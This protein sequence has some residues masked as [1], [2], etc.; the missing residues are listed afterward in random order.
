MLAASVLARSTV[1]CGVKLAWVVYLVLVISLSADVWVEDWA[2]MRGSAELMVLSFIIM[3][4]ARD[5]RLVAIA[6]T[7]TIAIW[8]ALAVRTVSAL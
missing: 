5:R 6:L 4:G 1:D 8:M 3:M 2:F 7:L